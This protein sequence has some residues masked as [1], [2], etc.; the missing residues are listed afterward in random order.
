MT[1]SSS[2]VILLMYSAASLVIQDGVFCLANFDDAFFTCVI[3]PS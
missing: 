2:K 3:Q 1:H